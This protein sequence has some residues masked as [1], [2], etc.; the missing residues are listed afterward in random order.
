MITKTV[1]IDISIYSDIFA[2]IK[3]NTGIEIQKLED[4]FGQLNTIATQYFAEE[5]NW[6][7]KFLKLPA[8][9]P[10]FNIDANSR[11]IEIPGEFKSNGLSVQGDNL[12]ETVF[13]KIAR[14]FDYM[15]LSTCDISINWKMGT[16]TGKTKNFILSTNI[17]PGYI[18]FGWPVDSTITK[19]NGSLSF[20]VE[21]SKTGKDENNEEI[22]TYSF[23]TLAATINIKEGLIV[24]NAEVTNL[25]PNILKILANSQFGD[26]DA[27]VGELKWFN[28]EINL[29]TDVD[30]NSFIIDGTQHIY[31]LETV[32]SDDG[33]ANSTTATFYANAYVDGVTQVDYTN[34][35]DKVNRYIEIPVKKR[36]KLVP[37]AEGTL[38][39]EGNDWSEE[40][41]ENKFKR[42]FDESALNNN[43]VYYVKVIDNN[44]KVAY[45]PASEQDLKNPEI[46]LYIRYG[47][48][49]IGTAGTYSINAQ[50]QKFSVKRDE[51]NNEITD[52]QGNPINVLIGNGPVVSSGNIVIPAAQAP[53]SVMVTGESALDL[54]APLPTG[55]SIDSEKASNVVFVDKPFL[56]K[57]DGE[58]EEGVQY[59]NAEGETWVEG[60]KYEY[61]NVVAKLTATASFAN[62]DD[63]GALSFIVNKEKNAPEF[64]KNYTANNNNYIETFDVTKTDMADNG[65]YKVEVTA[66]NYKNGTSSQPIVSN[67]FVVSK[68]AGK[69][70]NVQV[71]YKLGAADYSTVNDVVK[72]KSNGTLAQRS[73]TLHIGAVE[74]DGQIGT[75]S[76]EWYKQTGLGE[77]ASREL[78]SNKA[79]LVISSGDGQFIPVVKNNYNGSIFTLELK[80]VSVDDVA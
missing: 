8:E 7:P 22:K 53:E 43:I 17:E 76:Y 59:Y 39:A 35:A 51:N 11:K 46:A 75:L 79:E 49:E 29:G 56:Q 44:N 65:D 18:I 2:D 3:K 19:K 61:S 57:I 5:N 72:Y 63:C 58:G 32:V 54:S 1:D 74:I 21:F 16:E 40:D 38:D 37:D 64:Y 24:N 9:E 4:L 13:F 33:I 34:N 52:E 77:D 30:D 45:N 23:N 69:I 60:D 36:F 62:K 55:Y 71:E 80:S 41:G 42:E 47:A 28:A 48:I 68:L 12:A 6:D 20:A 10:T 73:V 15:D 66:V 70:T 78:V 67:S 50:G 25:K 26:G 27:A 31:N 14:Y